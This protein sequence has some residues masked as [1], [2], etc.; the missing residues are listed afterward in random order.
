MKFILGMEINFCSLKCT[1]GE[2]LEASCV[3]EKKATQNIKLAMDSLKQGWGE[4]TD[5]PYVG[6]RTKGFSHYFVLRVNLYNTL[7]GKHLTY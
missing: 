2:G 1:D 7:I 6:C 4:D 5:N 3:E